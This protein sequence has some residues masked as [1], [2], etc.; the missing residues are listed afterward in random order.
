MTNINFN[1][2]KANK[3]E[4]QDILEYNIYTNRFSRLPVGH[5]EAFTSALV[6]TVPYFHLS[7]VQ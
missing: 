5:L 6:R 4:G 1:K 7:E 3:S 2:C